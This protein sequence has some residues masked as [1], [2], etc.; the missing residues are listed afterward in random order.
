VAPTAARAGHEE[1]PSPA[2]A[3]GVAARRRRGAVRL[4]SAT[5]QLRLSRSWWQPQA[6]RDGA[7][8][9]GV[10]VLPVEVAL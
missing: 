2:F 7:V 9:D 3:G 8:A 6:D 1:Q 4:P 10:G 5:S